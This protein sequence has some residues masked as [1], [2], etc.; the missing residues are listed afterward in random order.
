MS[1]MSSHFL[2]N[3]QTKLLEKRVDL[4]EKLS[5]SIFLFSRKNSEKHCEDGFKQH[6]I[7]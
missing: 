5:V 1:K 7:L 2:V 4:E 6:H 3:S